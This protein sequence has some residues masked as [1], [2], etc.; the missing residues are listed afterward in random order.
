M[1]TKTNPNWPVLK[2][3]DLDHLRR[4]ALPLGGLGTGTVSLGGRGDLRDWEIVNRPAKGFSPGGG[5]VSAFF[6]LWA[7]PAGGQPVTKLLEGPM[8]LADY[9]GGY[10]SGCPVPNHG[11]PRFRNCEFAAAYPL[12]Q[13]L[14]SDP[15]MPVDVRLEAFN[16]L[17]PPDADASGLPVAVL[18]YVLTNRTSRRVSASICASVVN[19]IGSDGYI[20]KDKP[21]E[22]PNVNKFRTSG[23]LR[24]IFMSSN[25]V[26]PGAEQFG[27]MALT[28]T[29]PGA[30]SHW[31]NWPAYGRGAGAP[32]LNL[33]DDFADDGK[34]SPARP[35]DDDTPRAFMTVAVNVPPR[36]TRSITFLLTWHFPNRQTWTS[37]AESDC[38]PGG[39]CG[40]NTIGNYYAT[41]FRDAWDV[42]RKVAAELPALE[43]DTVAFVR[44]VTD[45]DLPAEIREASLF[46]LSVL[47]SQ[48][49]FRTPDGRFYGFEGCTMHGGCC[50]GSCTHVW[51]YEHATAFLFGP[52]ARVMRDI[53]FAHA[54]DDRGLMSFRVHL[55]IA[56]AQEFAAAA[57]DGQ[58]GC[59]MKIYRDWQLSGDER[60]LRKLWPGVRRSVEFC[61]VKGGW[62]GDRDGVMEG[63][64]HNTMDVEY[65]GPNPLMQSLYLGALRAAEEMARHLGECDFAETCSR[66]FKRGS[67]WMD[68]NMFNGEFYEHHIRPIRREKVAEGLAIGMF[69]GSGK[70]PDFQLGP[71]CLTDQLLGQCMAH[72]CGL[73]YLH[74]PSHVRKALKSVMKY[75]WRDDMFD[76]F[77]YARSFVLGGEPG[78]IINTWPRGGR[79]NVPTPYGSEIW[80]G[81]EYTAAANMLA[82]GQTA[83]GLKI[84]RAARD[85]HDGRKRNP[86]NEPECG[87]H[88]ARTM[89]SWGTLVAFTG[90]GYSGV[91][92]AVRFAPAGAA[93]ATT[94]FWSNGDAWGMVTQKRTGKKIAVELSVLRGKLTI[95]QLTLSGWG[96]VELKGARTVRPGKTLQTTVSKD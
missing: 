96:A 38:C 57:A 83:A 56:R 61:W 25:G 89:A 64:Q 88:Y 41:Q 92:K 49:C 68:E 80:T 66:L 5:H 27:T 71:A 79:P 39:D 1:A 55:P 63:C 21:G 84:V 2:T 94:W 18:R 85:R 70:Q 50:H 24:G 78:L 6:A 76:H 14:L 32:M 67:K 52:I 35:A 40:G 37:S 65:F 44:A 75:N 17:V 3:Y 11:L 53:E 90:F 9:E 74:K 30:M 45:N 81:I 15:K 42:A 19:F 91:T 69:G 48:T 72:I 29:A 34:L 73:G 20:S 10:G 60:M 47:R 82:E 22:N 51:N 28:T 7:K 8:D 26:D 13:V 77:N 87:N 16:P 33:W 95:K 86:F 62:D 23:K 4:I 12:G 54:T 31:R 36:G 93:K 46:N 59:V 58:M 43:R